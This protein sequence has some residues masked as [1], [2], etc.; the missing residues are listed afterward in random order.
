MITIEPGILDPNFFVV[1]TESLN[2]VLSAEMASNWATGYFNDRAH[3]DS[4]SK[5]QSVVARNM[6]MM[7]GPVCLDKADWALILYLDDTG[8]AVD[9]ARSDAPWHAEDVMKLST[10]GL[11]NLIPGEYGSM[12]AKLTKA[13]AYAKAWMLRM[14]KG[15]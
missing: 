12:T 6:E 2:F 11:I 1:R 9:T 3:E 10:M 4:W 8:P 15:E 7:K 5:E 14:R 13:G